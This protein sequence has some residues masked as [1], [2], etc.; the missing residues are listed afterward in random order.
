MVSTKL[1]LRT[2]KIR[3]RWLKA[4][5][6]PLLAACFCDCPGFFV[7]CKG[8]DTLRGFRWH[9]SGSF[10]QQSISYGEKVF[11][12]A[13]S[14]DCL[15]SEQTIIIQWLPERHGFFVKRLCLGNL[16]LARQRTGCVWKG[17]RILGRHLDPL[18]KT[19]EGGMR[20]SVLISWNGVTEGLM[21]CFLIWLLPDVSLYFC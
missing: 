2:R 11:C 7:F 3:C 19:R 17:Q 14:V 13:K 6:I 5:V 21:V 12:R 9:V 4:R 8:D 15:E 16:L 1:I 10:Q 20:E 18:L